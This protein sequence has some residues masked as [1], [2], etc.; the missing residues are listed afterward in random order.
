MTATKAA[1]K[2]YLKSQLYFP[3]YIEHAGGVLTTPSDI[4]LCALVQL[5]FF[6]FKYFECL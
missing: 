1:I 6:W 3:N 4:H 2:V 5:I